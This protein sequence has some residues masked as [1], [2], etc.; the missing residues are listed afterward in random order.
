VAERKVIMANLTYGAT[1]RIQNGFGGWDGN[2]L[3]TRGQSCEDN[4]LCV[5]TAETFDRDSG[6]GTWIILSATGKAVGDL[7]LSGDQVYLQNQYKSGE[8]YNGGY[9]DTR[10]RGCEDN[11]LC[12]STAETF[13][14]NSG[15][16]TWRLIKDSSGGNVQENDVVH[17]WNGWGDWTGGFLDTRGAGC[18]GN[19][20]CVSTS[21]NWNRDT[22]ST[23][24]RFQKQ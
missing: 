4:L 16:G 1:Y 14:R 22:G 9:L 11:L 10:G 20:Y 17:L 5:S 18:E 13:D 7:V 15:S 19:L 21:A 23:Q 3:D 2:Y 6:S 24:W 8:P 12:V